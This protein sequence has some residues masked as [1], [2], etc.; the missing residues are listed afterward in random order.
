MK[1]DHPP[2]DPTVVFRSKESFQHAQEIVKPFGVLEAV[3]AWCKTN[4]EDE[5]R[6]QLLEM[7]SDIKPGRYIF[8]FDSER[9][10][11]AFV[12]KWGDWRG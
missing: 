4:L 6:W 5:W 1:L 2:I 9:D 10:Y 11:L 3:L 8:F 12:L 7:S